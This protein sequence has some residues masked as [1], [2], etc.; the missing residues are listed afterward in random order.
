MATDEK[1]LSLTWQGV[2]YLCRTVAPQQTPT[3][4]PVLVLGWAM[5]DVRGWPRLERR[6]TEHTTMIIPQLPCLDDAPDSTDHGF[7]TF[8]EGVRH[9]LDQLGLPCVNLL[10]V[11]YGAP[12]AYR[13]A[14]AHPGR[15][16]RLLLAG[17]TP[18]LGPAMASLVRDLATRPG[19]TGD[20][21]LDR[22]A[23]DMCARRMADVLVNTD[24]ADQVPMAPAV[25]RML[26]RYFVE[27]AGAASRYIAYHRPL[28]DQDLYPP[29][30]LHGLPALVFTGEHDNVSTPDQ[31]RAVAATIS[32]STC[33]MIKNAD[34]MA[35][36][37]R[38]AEYADLV[39]RFI[40]DLPLNGLS[41]CTPPL[42]YAEATVPA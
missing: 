33:L 2:P 14:R 38:E 39:I 27:Q 12:I 9:T 32:G 34:H 15:I 7:D 8:V 31:N 25:R 19:P 21:A 5:Q 24:R 30:G 26:H 6:V 29:G 28:L 40:H 16:A 4:E 41:Y 20:L 18:S 36:L 22:A 17:A 37:E 35:H 10:G 1:I 42:A 11:S 13:V 3:T 23:D